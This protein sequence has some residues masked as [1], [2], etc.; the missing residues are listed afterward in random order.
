MPK[1]SKQKKQQLNL[2]IRQSPLNIFT[3]YKER[4]ETFKVKWDIRKYTK[5]FW[6][7]LTIVLSISLIITQV[8]TI[9]EKFFNLPKKIPLFQMYVNSSA[10]LAE[11]NYIYLIPVVSITIITAG[12]IFSNKYY[13]KERDLSN[14]LLLGMFLANLIITI[15]LI[16]LVNLY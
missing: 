16:R 2:K 4:V 3:K 7:W 9:Y 13:N 8:Y 11:T 14:T 5:S 10:V 12:I 6:V 1:V 15:A